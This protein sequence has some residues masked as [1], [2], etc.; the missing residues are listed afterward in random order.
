MRSEER[1]EVWY[2]SIETVYSMIK[3]MS[4]SRFALHVQTKVFQIF[5]K[6]TNGDNF[7]YGNN[8]NPSICTTCPKQ[9]VSDF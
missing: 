9:G 3:K 5:S 6:F 8:P 2:C 1:P 7:S 4:N